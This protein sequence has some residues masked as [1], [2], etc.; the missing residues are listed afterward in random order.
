MMGRRCLIALR[1]PI[2]KQQLDTV[3]KAVRLLGKRNKYYIVHITDRDVSDSEGVVRKRL[4]MR[5]PVI[6]RHGEII[7]ELK[8]LV[9]QLDI[10]ILIL[11]SH[12]KNVLDIMLEGI[13]ETDPTVELIKSMRVNILIVK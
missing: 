13:L 5:I 11:G 12:R 10:D 1:Y 3:E 9:K 2:R 6:S 8:R 4:G 7:S